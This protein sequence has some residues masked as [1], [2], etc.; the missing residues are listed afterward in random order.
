MEWNYPTK[1][2]DKFS[3][4]STTLYNDGATLSLVLRGV[5]FAGRDLDSLKPN[6][7]VPEEL[8]NQFTLSHDALCEC[9]LDI[10]I[11]VPVVSDDRETDAILDV[12]LELG[13]PTRTG[14]IDRERLSL[15]L[16]IA[17]NV[18]RSEGMSGWFEEELLSLQRA[19][20]QGRFLKACIACAYSDYSPYGH[21]LFGGMAC[22]RNFKTEYSLVKDKYDLFPILEQADRVQETYLCSDFVKRRPNTG[23]R[24]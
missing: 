17:N 19:M 23:Y 21:G 15:S 14:A 6:Q 5:R 16:R 2:S 9:T 4:E 13:V 8:L 20:P 11:P 24:G 7:A 3:T 1:Y 10:Q 22:F 18:Y 12:H